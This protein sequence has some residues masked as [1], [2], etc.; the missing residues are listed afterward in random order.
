MKIIN[1]QT[2]IGEG[3]DQQVEPLFDGLRRK[4]LQITLRNGAVLAAHKAASPITIQCLVGTATLRAGGEAVQLRPGVLAT[5]DASVVH[6]I[7]AE[8]AVTFLLT[9][10]TSESGSS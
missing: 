4:L 5:L 6:E 7:A 9:K 8:P 2:T 1:L 10:F 3:P